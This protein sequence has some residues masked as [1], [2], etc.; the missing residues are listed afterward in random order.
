MDQLS[1]DRVTIDLMP[2]HSWLQHM[3]EARLIISGTHSIPDAL[4]KPE[5]L[6]GTS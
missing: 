5:V 1:F 2:R 6:T 3:H 4:E